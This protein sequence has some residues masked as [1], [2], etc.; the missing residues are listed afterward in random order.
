MDSGA[1]GFGA[2]LRV[3]VDEGVGMTVAGVAMEI[4]NDDVDVVPG[5][6]L[7]R[8]A[9]GQIFEVD[10]ALQFRFRD[11]PVN[12]IAQIRVVLEQRGFSKHACHNFI[13]SLR[14]GR[15]GGWLVLLLVFWLGQAG[16]ALA[17][18][19]FRVAAVGGAIRM[20]MLSTTWHA[21]CPVA[22]ESLRQLSIT[23]RNYQGEKQK[24]E[25]VVHAEVAK[26]VLEIFRDLYRHGFR[27]EQ[28]NPVENYG[29]SDDASMAANNTSA[30][31]CR[32]V[33]GQTGKFSNHSWGR[34]IDI[35][36]LTNPYVKGSTVLPPEGRRHLDRQMDEAG[37]I[38]ADSYIV[39]RFHAAGWEWGGA[40]TDRKDY[41]H[42]EKPER[43][44]R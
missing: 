41:Q 1:D 31:N 18:D 19:E 38:G 22:V 15:F 32:D 4:A 42:F 44:K 8:S 13:R 5:L 27:I 3:S 7:K 24:G 28:I 9:V 6:D 36:P 33:T 20:K 34:A 43:P 11:V 21:G 2:E 39:K 25:L 12:L 10:S 40:W 29:G 37:S 14:H 30:F 35:N 23:Y 17:Q 16:K 26:E